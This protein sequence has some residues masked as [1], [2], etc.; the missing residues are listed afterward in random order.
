MAYGG[1]G[2][3]NLIETILNVFQ[4]YFYRKLMVLDHCGSKFL[5]LGPPKLTDRPKTPDLSVSYRVETILKFSDQSDV[6]EK[7]EV[8]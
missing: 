8:D 5:F 7:N 1:Y 4:V 3:G 2:N 6:L